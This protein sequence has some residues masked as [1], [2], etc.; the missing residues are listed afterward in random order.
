MEIRILK[1]SQNISKSQKPLGI[2][3]L[4]KIYRIYMSNTATNTMKETKDLT[5][6]RG[7][8]CSWIR[9]A[10]MRRGREFPHIDLQFNTTMSS[11]EKGQGISPM[12][13]YRFNATMSS[14]ERGQR[15]APMLIYRFNTT[16]RVMKGGREF[17]PRS[18]TGLMQP[19]KREITST[20]SFICCSSRDGNKPSHPCASRTSS[21]TGPSSP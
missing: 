8:P 19:W 16:M 11:N 15:I 17:P 7:I 1:E 2:R 3:L 10:I 4:K 6:K 18:S 12:L 5:Q 21:Y 20:Q 14:N 9:R 13:I